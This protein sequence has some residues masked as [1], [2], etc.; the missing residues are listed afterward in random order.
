MAKINLNDVQKLRE[1]TGVGVMDAKKAL[2]ASGGDLAEAIKAMREA[3]Q[4]IAEKKQDR[5]THAGTIG[6]YLHSNKKILA[7]VV[8]AC[9]TDFVERT[10]VFQELAHE[11]A[12]Q[13]AA[14]NPKYIS[15]EGLSTEVIKAET[16]IAKAQAEKAGRPAKV[17]DE[18]I[19]GKL[20]KFAEEYCLMQ[21]KFFKDDKLT[22]A[23]VVQAAVQKLG[24][25]IQIRE[26]IRLT[27]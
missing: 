4:K 11:L 7:A 10:A 17:I 1:Q 24:E 27:I 2:E 3:G 19:K 26:F 23:M 5:Q 22:V 9:E 8:V 15:A 13:V 18:I 6:V 16:E 21:Q 20:A 14:A 12:M 25:N